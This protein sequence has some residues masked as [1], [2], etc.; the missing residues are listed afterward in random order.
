M[1]KLLT[2]LVV[3]FGVLGGGYA[4]TAWTPDN[5]PMVH[6][7]DRTKYVI[8][9]DGILT[10]AEVATMDAELYGLERKT[11]TQTV[12]VVVRHIEDDDPY[13]FGQA[14]ADK[15]GIGKRGTDNG[16]FVMLCTGDRSY[17]ILTGD[18]LEGVLPDAICRR[19]QDRVMVPKLREGR[20]GE[21]MVATIHALAERIANENPDGVTVD[22]EEDG[23]VWAAVVTMM[24]LVFLLPIIIRRLSRKK[25]PRC[26]KYMKQVKK[27]LGRETIDMRQW[28]VTYCCKHCGHTMT[29]MENE[30]ISNDG[31][32]LHGPFVGGGLG[33]G[34]HFGG[35]SIG[36][37]FG[38]GHF[39]GG[40][41]T[42]RF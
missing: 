2:I 12:V 31:G 8:N 15:Y 38:G 37:S 4:Q 20:W 30:N 28:H 17:T 13:S 39:G 42:G 27:Q 24:V 21:A 18:G 1:K 6:L 23:S 7:M 16:L 35:G 14:V 10:A 5:L 41:S 9:P 3:L 40:G 26:G 11:G 29:V 32:G 19:I 34:G 33:R 22:D 25:C 36:G